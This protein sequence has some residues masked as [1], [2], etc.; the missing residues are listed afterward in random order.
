VSI[1][2][3]EI[4]DVY[5]VAVTYQ[6]GQTTTALGWENVHTTGNYIHNCNQSFEIWCKGDPLTGTG[7]VNCSFTDNTCE[8]AGRSWGMPVRPDWVGTGT[9]LLFYQTELA[10]DVTIT[11][12]TFYDAVSNYCYF[13]FPIP[14]DITIDDN[15]ISLLT[16]TRLQAQSATTIDNASTWVSATGIDVNSSFT[17]L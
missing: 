2:S 5:D 16:G 17:V 12:N 1:T 13:A 4:F 8:E 6:G 7:L 10:C 14:G 3:N 11:G 9:H 15:N